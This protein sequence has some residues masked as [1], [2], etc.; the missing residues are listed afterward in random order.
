MNCFQNASHSGI[1][2]IAPFL[3]LL[4]VLMFF[5]LFVLR[6]RPMSEDICHVII[7]DSRDL[8]SPEPDIVDLKGVFRAKYG[9]TYRAPVGF[10]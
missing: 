2:G 4:R 7:D 5:C 6:T 9:G 1:I 10:A 8:M 3:L